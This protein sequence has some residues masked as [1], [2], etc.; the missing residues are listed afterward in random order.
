[1]SQLQFFGLPPEPTGALGPAEV[2]PELHA[3]GA[4][5]PA[6]LRL[7]TSSWSFSGW[8]GI[9]Y[10]RPAKSDKLAREG[11]AAYAQHP[12]FRTVGLDR[13]Y[14][15]P[16]PLEAYQRYAAA[17][18]ADFRFLAKA[19][20]EVLSPWLTLER[21]GGENP[22]FLDAAYA[23]DVAVGPFVEG[24]GDKAGP[25]LFQFAPFDL[26]ILGGPSRFAE[27]LHAFLSALPPG[28]LYAVELRTK[29]AL[30]FDYA[31]A[32]QDLG[33]VHCF[34]VHSSM[35]RIREQA[36]RLGET[37]A[38]APAVVARWMLGAG[39]RYQ[40]AKERYQPFDRVVDED[41]VARDDLGLLLSRDARPR[42]LIVNNKAEGC[43]PRSIA[44]LAQ[45]LVALQDPAA[46][47]A[48][49]D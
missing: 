12:L 42:Y 28:P 19:P 26:T 21:G 7:G 46:D 39:L 47:G 30:G 37:Q 38:R 41:P 31:A 16:I 4:R 10:D 29:G 35:P 25:L 1:M 8:E 43:S 34:N 45:R 11:L 20:A 17:V 3:L 32:L 48:S 6:G 14:Y 18:P 49:H 9:V 13:G 15:A 27:R 5:L 22:R 24:L 40:D 36:E 2:P 44:A 33:V 23:T